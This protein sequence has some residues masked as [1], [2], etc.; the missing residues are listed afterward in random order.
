MQPLYSN[1]GFWFI[2]LLLWVFFQCKINCNSKSNN[3]LFNRYLIVVLTYE[4]KIFLCTY[5]NKSKHGSR[6]FQNVFKL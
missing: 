3:D 6:F 1:N 4:S 5:P 2:V